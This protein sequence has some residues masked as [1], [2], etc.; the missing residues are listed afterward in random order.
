MSLAIARAQTA[1]ESR[2]SISKSKSRRP[3]AG[4]AVEAKKEAEVC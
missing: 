3:S 4:A 2:L 1:A